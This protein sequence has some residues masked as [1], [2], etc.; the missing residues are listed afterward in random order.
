MQATLPRFQFQSCNNVGTV[1]AEVDLPAGDYLLDSFVIRSTQSN[2]KGCLWYGGILTCTGTSDSVARQYFRPFAL[3]TDPF[4][5][6]TAEVG[7]AAFALSDADPEINVLS[8]NATH[9]FG[10]PS[11]KDCFTLNLSTT[12]STS[13]NTGG[14]DGTGLQVGNGNVCNQTTSWIREIT[15]GGTIGVQSL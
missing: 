6:N 3:I 15:T 12:I 4:S 7:W 10:M 11:P 2:R 9:T 14:I 8:A 5:G 1:L 13:G